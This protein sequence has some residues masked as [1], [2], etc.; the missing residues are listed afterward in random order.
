[1]IRPLRNC[2]GFFFKQYFQL[3]N[4]SKNFG[5]GVGLPLFSLQIV[6]LLR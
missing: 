5:T 4:E 6:T 2:N 1:M 3:Q